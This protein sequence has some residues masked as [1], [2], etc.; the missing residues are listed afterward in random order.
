MLLSNTRR[1]A[2]RR[3]AAFTLLE[4]LVVVAILVI[5]AGV[6]VVA[7]TRYLD[8]AKKSKAQLQAATIYK[9]MEAFHLNPNSG[10]VYPSSLQ[11]LTNPPWGGSSFLNDPVADLTD[12]W[13]QQFQIQQSQANDNSVQGKPLVYTKA[14]DGVV[15]S[16]F[17]IGPQSRLQ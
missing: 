15:I 3:R 4:V 1:R 8:D 12:P 6:G 17:G 16:N 10:G 14:P 5:L 2:M 13:N 9:A 11:E 7:T